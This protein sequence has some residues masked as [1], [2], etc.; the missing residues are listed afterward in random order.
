M[1]YS[2]IKLII[3]DLDDTFWRGTLSEEQVYKINACVELVKRTTDCGV[4]NSICSK[5]SRKDAEN[6]LSEM[7]VLDLFVF[8]SIDWTPKGERIRNLIKDMGLR[9][10]NTLF[11][12]DNLQNLN[13]AKHYSEELM[14]GTPDI[15]ADLLKYFNRQEATDT[16]HERLKQYRILEEKNRSK[17]RYASNEDFLY[18]CN[19]QVE[20]LADCVNNIERIADLVQRSNQLNFTK[21]RSSK[22]ELL[23]DIIDENNE[24]GYVK[25]RDKFGDY[26]IIGFF[27]I[28]KD[29]DGQRF[30]KHFLFSCRTIGQGI[31]QYVYAKIG[32]PRLTVNGKTISTVTHADAP[33]WINRSNTALEDEKDVKDVRLLFKGPCDLMALTKYVKGTCHIDQEFTYIGERGNVIESQNHSISLKALIDYSDEERQLLVDE[34]M[35][36]D[37]NYY[38]SALFTQKYDMIFLSALEEANLGIYKRKENGLL[39]PFAEAYYPL[40][41]EKNWEKYIEGEIYFGQNKFTREFLEV[42]SRDYEFVG[43]STPETYIQ[44]LD[45]IISHIDPE[46]KIGI[47]IGSEKPYEK[48][49]LVS[50][51]NRHEDFRKFNA[52]IREYARRHKDRI[53][54]I[55]PNKYLNTQNDFYDNI[56]HYSLKVYFNMAQDIINLINTVCHVHAVERSSIVNVWKEAFNMFI[57]AQA[58][59]ILPKKGIVYD[60]MQKVYRKIKL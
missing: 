29:A 24:C 4:I 12:D 43:K 58:K 21:L 2:K 3:W 46:T 30:C 57:K 19:M 60:F 9:P 15:I 11:L 8:N 48:N 25:V 42:F 59:H 52:A 22:D 56:N 14:T 32:F 50:Y 17:E 28:S 16:E 13:E 35:F 26:G 33:G 54:V 5:N 40:T 18:S 10:A 41:D 45:E 20:I 36:M 34:C 37:K 55:D 31:E 47:F 53:F 27:C 51:D 23:A 1:D 7:G 44:R 49:S 6:Q 39:V 38:Q